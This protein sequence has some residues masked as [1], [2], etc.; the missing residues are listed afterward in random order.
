[1]RVDQGTLFVLSSPSGGGKSTIINRLRDRND[2]LAYSISVTTRPPRRGE[3]DGVAYFFLDEETFKKRI[4][5]VAFIEW[6]EV[7]GYYYGTLKKEIKRLIADGKKVLLDIDV[8]GGLA[9]KKSVSTAVLIFLIPPS[10]KTLEHRLQRRGTDS[11]DVIARRLENARKEVEAA[12][13]YDYQVWNHDLDKTV[14]EVETIIRSF[15]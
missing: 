1:M 5:E 14:E 15:K 12:E 3:R 13:R 10:L 9:L 11:E 8:Q 2:D 7:H 4:E 6:A